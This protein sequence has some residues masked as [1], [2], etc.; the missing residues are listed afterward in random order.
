MGDGGRGK[1]AGC[2]P[3]D[4]ASDRDGRGASCRDDGGARE[5]T[6]GRRGASCRDDGGVRE[7][8]VGRARH[9]R[10]RRG[11]SEAALSGRAGA[12]SR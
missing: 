6:V 8:T 10:E 5:A 9:C 7:A 11:E 3:S 1:A 4:A 12:L 2:G